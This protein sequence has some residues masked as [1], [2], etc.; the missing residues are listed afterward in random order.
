MQTFGDL[1]T[2]NPHIH[3]LV[4]DGVFLPTGTFRVLPP[5]PEAALREA[6]RHKLLD[7]LCTEG[8]LDA[9]L[10]E[11]M[12]NWRHSGFS[13]HNRVRSKAAVGKGRQHCARYMIRCPFALEKMRYD[14]KSGMVIYRS[15]LHA[16][17]KRNYQLMPALQWLRMLMNHIPDKYEHLVRYHGYYFNR[18]RGARRLV[19]NG[20][21]P[22]GPIRID[23]PPAD[24]RRKTNWARLI[25]KVYEIDPLKCVNC[26]GNLRIIALID[27]VDIIERTLKHLKV[28]HPRTEN[29]SPA[30]PDPPGPK[31]ETIPL[32][33]HP[34][35]DSA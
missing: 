27:D 17:L 35:P 8:V 21:E 33:Y 2:F 9:G 14:E 13:V 20:N 29:R 34:V 25:Q 12:L 26:G 18:S 6:L 32:S 5:L 1:V 24:N 15:R 3:A 23:E 28:W 11:R 19:E 22:A 7:F 31:G 4:A 16:T 30:G 10:A